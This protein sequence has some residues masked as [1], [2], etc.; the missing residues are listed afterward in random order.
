MNILAVH[1]FTSTLRLLRKKESFSTRVER[2][3]QKS[4]EKREALDLR[5]ADSRP[6]AQRRAP[7]VSS[8]YRRGQS[9]GGAR[10]RAGE[11]S[12]LSTAYITQSGGWEL[13]WRS[14]SGCHILVGRLSSATYTAGIDSQRRSS[15]SWLLS[16]A[17]AM[18]N[19]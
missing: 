15:A 16:T 2:T 4:V 17:S 9:S 6:A 13:T 10:V 8:Q 18:R 3:R 1:A 19:R 7:R 14:L 5:R 11:T 12:G